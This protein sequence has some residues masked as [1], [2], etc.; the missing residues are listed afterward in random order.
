MTE[1][2]IL[3]IFWYFLAASAA[4]NCKKK[5]WSSRLLARPPRRGGCA[6]SRLDHGLKFY[7]MR[8]GCASSRLISGSPA[9]IIPKNDQKIVKKY[10]KIASVKWRNAVNPYDGMG[11]KKGLGRQQEKRLNP[12]LHPPNIFYR[13]PYVKG[14]KSQ[15]F[16]DFFNFSGRL[17]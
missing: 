16:I 6:S 8:G 15:I 1:S 13:N 11:T 14:P 12:P 3:T 2:E 5:T 9:S 10:R 4:K 17:R 7:V